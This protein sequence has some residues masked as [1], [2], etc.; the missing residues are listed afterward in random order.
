MAGAALTNTYKMMHARNGARDLVTRDLISESE[1]LANTSTAQFHSIL[2]KREI[3][4]SL[5]G[6]FF[7][8]KLYSNCLLQSFA[9][10]ERSEDLAEL[11]RKR[12]KT[13]DVQVLES[14]FIPESAAQALVEGNHLKFLMDRANAI[15]TFGLGLVG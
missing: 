15:Y 7:S 12:L 1:Y 8:A 11:V 14:Q 2:S 10:L 9:S 13:G 4:E 6:E 3:S 5:D